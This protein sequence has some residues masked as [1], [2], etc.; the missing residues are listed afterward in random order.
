M[1]SRFRDY[2][3]LNL[4]TNWALVFRRTKLFPFRSPQYRGSPSH[5]ISVRFP[6]KNLWNSRHAITILGSSWWLFVAVCK[7][8]HLPATVSWALENL[9]LKILL[10]VGCRKS[11]CRANLIFC[12]YNLVANFS[13]CQ[14]ALQ[15]QYELW[16]SVKSRRKERGVIDDVFDVIDSSIIN[17]FKKVADRLQSRW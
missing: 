17:T 16:E 3:C 1:R 8:V 10:S 12:E 9:Q 6:C 11:C 7:F 14:V 5:V 13:C 2:Q 4:L 15:I